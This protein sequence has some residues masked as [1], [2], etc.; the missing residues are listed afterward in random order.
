M[1]R[2]VSSVLI[3]FILMGLVS[4]KTSEPTRYEANFIELF[5][6]VTQIVSYTN[7]KETF[8]GY[9]DQIY[10]EL[11]EY[12]RLY[13]IYNDYDGLNNIKTINDNA[14]INPVKVDRRIIDLL[15]FSK[16]IYTMTDGAVNVAFGSVLSIWHDYREKGIN[17]PESAELPPVEMLQNASEHADISNLIIDEEALTVFLKDPEMRLDLGAVAKGYAVERIAESIQKSGFSSGLISVGGN[18]RAIG[19]KPGAKG[20]WNLGIQNP[21][22]SSAKG[23]LHIVYLTDSSLVTSGNYI[24]YYTVDGKEYHHII[25]PLTLYPSDKFVAVS[26]ICKDSGYADAL[27][28]AL[29]V[30]P[31]EKGLELLEKIPDTHAF[32]IMPDGSEIYSPGFEDFLKEE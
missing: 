23:N 13:D 2:I 21:D 16:E 17:D 6:T 28:T 25:D 20:V 14:G 30:L 10:S 27:S 5:D 18:V 8:S 9:V 12:H 26:V 22:T 15:I 7:S 4:C 1:K 32:W 11:S 31:Y 24:R 19:L 29:Y 3:S